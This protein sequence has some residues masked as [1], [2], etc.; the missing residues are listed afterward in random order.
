MRPIE[1]ALP[2]KTRVIYKEQS[3]VIV[4]RC[5]VAH[6]WLYGVR[7]SPSNEIIDYIPAE[8]L[9]HDQTQMQKR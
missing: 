7:I 3:A 4:S 5:Y 1:K 9:T 6:R 8:M 2:L